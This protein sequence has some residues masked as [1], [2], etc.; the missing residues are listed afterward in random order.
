M[1]ESLQKALHNIICSCWNN[2]SSLVELHD[3]FMKQKSN[4]KLMTFRTFGKYMKHQG[5][6]IISKLFEKVNEA[7]RIDSHITQVKGDI[8]V[9]KQAPHESATASKTFIS[10]SLLK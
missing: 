5:P 1:Q 8:L 6:Y 4:V 2:K 3:K 10:L 7:A 9:R